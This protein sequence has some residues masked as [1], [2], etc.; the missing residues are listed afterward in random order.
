MNQKKYFNLPEKLNGIFSGWQNK[1]QP[2]SDKRN[3][4][5]WQNVDVAQAD[6]C[7]FKI[8]TWVEKSIRCFNFKICYFQFNFLYEFFRLRLNYTN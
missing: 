5:F 2:A 3:V 6:V 1:T 7:C 8:T 4:F